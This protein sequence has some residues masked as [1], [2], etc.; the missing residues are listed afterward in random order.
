M[1]PT[2]LTFAIL[3]TAVA[4]FAQGPSLPTGVG[5]GTAIVRG[6]I[7]AADTGKPLKRARVSFAPLDVP[8]APRSVTTDADGRYEMKE[9]AGGRYSVSVDRSGYLT[10]RYGQRRPLEAAK[11]LQVLDGQT[12]E[13]VNFMLPRTGLIAGQVVDEVGDAVAGATIFAFRSEYW[14]GRRQL[15]P[16]GPAAKTDDAGRYRITGLSPGTYVVRAMTR[17]TW[18]VTHGDTKETMAFAPTYF[19]G[20]PDVS[21]AQR[22]TV[23]IGQQI[24]GVNFPMVPGKTVSVSGTAVNS[25]GRPLAQ[26]MLVQSA[27]GPNGGFTGS[28][29]SSVVAADGTFRIRDVAPGEYTLVAAGSEEVVRQP[30]TIA[31]ADVDDIALVAAGGWSAT[32]LVRTESGAPLSIRTN[33]VRVSATSAGAFAGMRLSGEPMYRQVLNDDWTFSVSGV[34]GP[35]RFRVVLPDGW[36]VRS[37]LYKGRD[38]VDAAVEP[39]RNEDALSD[40]EIVLTDRI[41]TVAGQ[42]VDKQGGPLDGTVIVFSSDREKWRDNSRWVRSTRPDQTGQFQIKSLPPGDY[43]AVAVDFAQ[44]GTWNDPEYLE[45]ISHDALHFTLTEAESKTI[46]LALGTP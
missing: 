41:T 23:G 13:K 32:G 21:V 5:T 22:V 30:M 28:G 2:G 6:Q 11:P 1:T 36:A 26:V 27:L 44:D 45:S 39:G 17:E 40:V 25:H 42:L 14:Q 38:V 18:T 37:I 31:M 20:T 46:S 9:L 43:L 34:V 8:G 12:V 29:G 7:V 10:L 15:V 4:A 16:S 3:S 33:R 24:S 19:P 35:A